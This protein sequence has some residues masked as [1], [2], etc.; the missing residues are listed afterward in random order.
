MKPRGSRTATRGKGDGGIRVAR[1]ERE[2]QSQIARFLMSS[3]KG[4]LPGLVTL[5]LVKMPADLKSA[6]V[7]VSFLNATP[8]Q[9]KKGVQMLQRRAAE[10]QRFLSDNLELR[11]CPKLTFEADHSTEKIMR[12]DRIIHELDARH[13]TN[14]NGLD[15]LTSPLND[16]FQPSTKKGDDSDT[17]E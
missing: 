3:Y 10:I 7:F 11:F 17:E 14:S 15:N 13:T 1:V 4:E 2:V 9:E 8:A 16:G 12:I 6:R 5:S